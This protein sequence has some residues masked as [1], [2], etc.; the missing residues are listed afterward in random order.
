MAY[1]EPNG[2]QM[3]YQS[4]LGQ[5]WRLNKLFCRTWYG[6]STCFTKTTFYLFTTLRTVIRNGGACILGRWPNVAA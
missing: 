6:R 5:R 2:L 3:L 4:I 1:A